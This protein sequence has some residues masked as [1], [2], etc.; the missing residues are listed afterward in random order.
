MTI[1]LNDRL[2]QATVRVEKCIPLFGAFC[3]DE[4][5]EE[6]EEFF[7][8]ADEN[9]FDRLFYGIDRDD[10]DTF[11]QGLLHNA[12]LGFLVQVSTPVMRAAGSG[13]S[14]SWGSYYLHWLYADT[15][16]S[17][18][19]QAEDWAEQRRQSERDKASKAA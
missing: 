19:E 15:M 13:F 18:I 10:L 9:D 16:E 17:L 1:E 12:K 4:P 5:N 2:L 6:L 8:N 11:L 3:E 7:D 14:Y